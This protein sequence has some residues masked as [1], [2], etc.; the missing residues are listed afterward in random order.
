MFEDF[1][2]Y[3]WSDT[4]F[5]Q[6]LPNYIPDIP[7]EFFGQYHLIFSHFNLDKKIVR[8]GQN[9]R[10][11]RAGNNPNSYGSNRE[12]ND[13]PDSLGLFRETNRNQKFPTIN[14]KIS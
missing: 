13:T 10:Q 8:I 6:E 5:D 9:E 14:S 11:R 7:Q 1:S 4:K 12:T 2:L 3:V